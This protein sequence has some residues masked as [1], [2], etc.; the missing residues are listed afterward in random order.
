MFLLDLL[1]PRSCAFCGVLAIHSER[2]ICVNCFDDLPWHEP[3]VSPTPGL[4]ECSIAMLRYEFPVDVAIKALKFNRR[5][6]YAP[7]FA[8]VLCTAD[9]FLPKDIDAVLPVPLHWWRKTRRGFNQ[10]S[11]LAKPVAKHLNVRLLRGVY[12]RKATPSQSGLNALE[13]RRNLKQAFAVRKPLRANHVL[14][15]D[16]V[17]TTGTTLTEL[18][19]VLLRDGVRKVSA[20][21]V[22]SAR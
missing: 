17:V 20:L 18:A 14:I 7:A 10:A 4:F 3:T 2:N 21:T 8:E 12:R 19:R 15:I 9:N 1:A 13:R 22:A 6:F 16:D 11:E 5:L